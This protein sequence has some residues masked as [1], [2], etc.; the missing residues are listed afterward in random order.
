M[1]DLTAMKI[2]VRTPVKRVWHHT[3]TQFCNPDVSMSD[4]LDPELVLQHFERTVV[5]NTFVTNN[6]E[7]LVLQNYIL[8]V[9]IA[10][11]S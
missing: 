4:V 3:H 10:D 9:S 2:L 8:I 11:E 7:E 1:F 6:L 5:C